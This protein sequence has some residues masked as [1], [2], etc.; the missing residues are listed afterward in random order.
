MQGYN[1][2]VVVTETQIIVAA[3]VTPEENDVKQVQPMLHEAAENVTKI[4]KKEKISTGLM[5]AGYW[6]ENNVRE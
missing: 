2:Q 6:S 1:G 5:H 4:G 3:D